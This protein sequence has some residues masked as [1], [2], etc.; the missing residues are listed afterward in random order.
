MPIDYS[1]G[2][3]YAIRSHQTEQYYIGSTVQTLA[4]RLTKHRD[5]YKY[6]HKGRYTMSSFEIL[7]YD[8]HYIE[9][10]ELCP[11]TCKSELHRR[12]G[13]LIR[14]H[15]NCVNKRIAGRSKAEYIED[16][17]ELVRLRK[18]RYYE[19]NKEK[20][21]AYRKQWRKDNDNKIRENLKL[22]HQKNKEKRNAYAKKWHREN[23]ERMN[24][25]MR[26]RYQKN[27]EKYLAKV[28]CTCGASVSSVYI[29]QHQK[30]KK[31]LR[32]LGLRNTT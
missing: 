11:C 18:K 31:H 3:I 23:K 17:K 21:D 1:K 9:L 22:Y 26:G 19:Q 32:L 30:T 29:K 24:A 7:Q 2:K 14:E 12:E 13:Q 28:T 6:N 27:K 15:I 16:N 25:K 10:L 8:D 4:Q 20:L 5:S